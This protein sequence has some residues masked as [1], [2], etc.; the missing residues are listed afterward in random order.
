MVRITS[1]E[2]AVYFIMNGVRGHWL[3]TGDGG[4]KKLAYDFDI[5]E[6]EARKLEAEFRRSPVGKFLKAK[7]KLE[8]VRRIKRDRR[9]V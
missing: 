2:V 3:F 5:K 9:P 7:R 8:M 4:R 1:I 6:A